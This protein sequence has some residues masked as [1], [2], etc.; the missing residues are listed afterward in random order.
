M[1][2]LDRELQIFFLVYY[3]QETIVTDVRDEKKLQLK[4]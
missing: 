4:V 3:P 1:P 2:T